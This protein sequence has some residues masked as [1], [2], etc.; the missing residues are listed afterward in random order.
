[1]VNSE[2]NVKVFSW[3]EKSYYHFWNK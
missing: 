3:K 1:L 2:K